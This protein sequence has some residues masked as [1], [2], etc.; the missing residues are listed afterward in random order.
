[1]AQNAALIVLSYVA[2]LECRPASSRLFLNQAHRQHLKSKLR[3][4]TARAQSIATF[5]TMSTELKH[6][7]KR[8]D[9][10]SELTI[11]LHRVR[12]KRVVPFRTGTVQKKTKVAN[13]ALASQWKIS[14]SYRDGLCQLRFCCSVS[15]NWL[16][17]RWA[18]SADFAEMHR[19]HSRRSRAGRFQSSARSERRRGRRK[20]CDR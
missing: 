18:W 3:G 16:S 8:V 12:I 5:H 2:L 11:W 19:S 13:W 7:V 15:Q 20:N 14:Y 1:M 6:V 17:L 10:P 4:C 9:W